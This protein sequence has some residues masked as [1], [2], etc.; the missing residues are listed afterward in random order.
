MNEMIMS[1][2]LVPALS[3]KAPI[4]YILENHI[5]RRKK[6]LQS[7][8]THI[9][10]TKKKIFLFSISQPHWRRNFQFTKDPKKIKA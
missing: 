7:I 9:I 8:Q 1:L 6:V 3:R 2:P 4:L 5:H 10:D